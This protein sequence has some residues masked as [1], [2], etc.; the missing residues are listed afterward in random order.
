MSLVTRYQSMAE[1]ALNSECDRRTQNALVQT[2][3]FGS[4]SGPGRSILVPAYLL[5]SKL[6]D[7]PSSQD[8][9]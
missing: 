9:F 3:T 8:H 2:D 5:T 6:A 4:K 7:T 1:S